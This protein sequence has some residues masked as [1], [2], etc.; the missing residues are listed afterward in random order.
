MRIISLKGYF[1]KKNKKENDS[2]IHCSSYRGTKQ[3]TTV[4]S[5]LVSIYVL[6]ILLYILSKEKQE[7]QEAAAKNKG[8]I[9]TDQKN[10][11]CRCSRFDSSFF[12]RSNIPCWFG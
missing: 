4:R 7:E 2:W 5:E 1:L 6:R 11:I 8:R 3:A 9:N 12:F 10:R